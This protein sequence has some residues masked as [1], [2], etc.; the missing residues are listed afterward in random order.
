MNIL[1]KSDPARGRK[2][3]ELLAQLAPE[4]D[5]RQWPETGDPATVEYLVAWQPPADIL[6]Q[7]PNLKVLFSVGAG[8]DQF[9]YQQLPAELPVV[10][11]V[12]QGLINGMVEYVT[13]AVLGLH[14]DMPRYLQQQREQRWQAHPM[15]PA[16]R[17]RIG[18]MGLGSLG[19]AVLKPLLALGFDCGG[20]SRTPRQIEG[21]RCWA[22]NDQLGDFLARSDILVCLLPL[23]DS[24]RGILNAACFN[25]LPP[26]AAL[27]QAGRGAQLSH[28][29]L[30]QALDSQ[31]LSAAVVDVTDPEPLPADHPFWRHPAIWLTPHIASQTVPETAVAALLANIRRFEAG[32]PMIGLIDR[33][34]G[35]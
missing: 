2:W 18:V 22:G 4:A 7:F 12:E 8:A 9:D 10:R 15:L 17:R 5:F 33:Q 26:G 24:T 35:Y 23:T 3:A 25:Q 11:M 32:E 31:Q 14:R 6:Q 30:L 16:S 34:K 20:W 21:V 1:Y 13:F 27:V 28:D 19:E 29:D